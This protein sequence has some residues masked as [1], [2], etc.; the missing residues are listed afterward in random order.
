MKTT[1]PV[2]PETSPWRLDG[3]RALVTGGTKG[4]GRATVDEL[5]ALGAD[6]LFC[7]RD[8]A[9]VDAAAA[10]TG[11]RGIAADVTT[12][13]GRAAIEEAVR[14]AGPLDVLVNNVGMNVRRPFVDY[15][16]EEIARIVETNLIAFLALTRA[17]HPL[18]ARPASIVN[19]ASVAGVTALRTG[20]PYAVTKAAMIQATRSLAL[21]WAREGIRVNAVAPWYTET[22]LAAPVLSRPEARATIVARTPLGRVA[23]PVEVARAIAFLALEASSYVTGQCLAVDGGFTIHGLSWD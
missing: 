16:E 12:A 5:R 6:V 7:A 23:Q 19:V 11:A 18:L 9:E 15:A 21:E 2:R 4:I 10:A 1:D 14:A 3:R 13:A 22:P 20:V 8:R 17:L